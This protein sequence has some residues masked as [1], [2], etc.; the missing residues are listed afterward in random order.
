MFNNDLEDGFVPYGE[1]GLGKTH[2]LVCMAKRF[3]KRVGGFSCKYI[4]A[5][6]IF[7]DIRDTYS[8]NSLKTEKQIIELYRGVKYL[9]ID[10]IGSGSNSNAE[11]NALLQILDGRQRNL[12][13]TMLTSN[14][15]IDS[16]GKHIGEREASR[17]KMYESIE[18]TGNDKRGIN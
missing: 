7:L 18:F 13:L 17:F 16:L 10:D 9:F 2:C 12:K 6:D 4:K 3:I 14:M 11:R 15:D 8:P 1:K 5:S